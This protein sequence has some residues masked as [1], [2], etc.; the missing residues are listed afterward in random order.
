MALFT[1]QRDISLFRHLNREL[2][3][4]IITQQCVY[5]KLQLE[6]T[7]V[8]IYGEASGA[9]FYNPPVILNALIARDDQ[10]QPV[11]D[12]GVD[13]SWNIEFRFFRDDLVDANLVPEVGDIIMYN[14]GYYEVDGTNAN[15]FFSGKN[16]DYPNE[17]NPLNPGLDN[18]GTSVSIICNTH[19][20]PADRV[21]IT[22]ERL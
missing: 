10:S 12:L 2:L 16:P 9:K 6:E 11:S 5:Y 3:W 21:S 4:D 19:Y 22:R 15:Q 13:F 1:T 8:N 18:F 14:E 17:P 7:K 20:V